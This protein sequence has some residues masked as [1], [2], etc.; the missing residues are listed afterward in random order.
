VRGT[1][2]AAWTQPDP[3]DTTQPDLLQVDNPH[4]QDTDANTWTRW[5]ARG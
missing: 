3:E 2:A 4:S 1:A 5:I